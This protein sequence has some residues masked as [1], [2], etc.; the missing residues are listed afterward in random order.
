[1]ITAINAGL[2]SDEQISSLRMALGLVNRTEAKQEAL[3]H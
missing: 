1:V 2:L 3:H